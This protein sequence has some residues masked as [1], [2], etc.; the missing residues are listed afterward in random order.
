[1]LSWLERCECELENGKA[2]LAGAVG[3]QVGGV[4]WGSR[5][6]LEKALL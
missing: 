2:Q 5:G 6:Q 4:G 1:M 3:V